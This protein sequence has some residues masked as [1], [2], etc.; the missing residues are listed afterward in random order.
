[1]LY[2]F[3]ALDAYAAWVENLA[4]AFAWLV[5]GRILL[6]AVLAR[7]SSQAERDRG[8]DVLL[9]AVEQ[10]WTVFS[11]AFSLALSLLRR[12]PE[13]S[14]RPRARESLAALGDM[15]GRFEFDATFSTMRWSVPP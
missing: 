7:S 10:P 6:A 1:M 14:M 12:W 5:D 2:R 15:A 3:G 4:H 13:E 8:F 11:E 9:R